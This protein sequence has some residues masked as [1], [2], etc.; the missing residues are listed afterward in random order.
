LISAGIRELV[1]EGFPLH[2]EQIPELLKNIEDHEHDVIDIVL[3]AIGN[4]RY[5]F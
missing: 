2:D 3:F 1:K 4:A 5:T